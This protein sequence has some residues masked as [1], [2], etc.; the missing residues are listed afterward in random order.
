[1]TKPTKWHVRQAKTQISLAIHTIFRLKG[2]KVGL[3]LSCKSDQRLRCPHE[4]AWV[5]RYPFS[6]QRRLMRSAQADL[7]LFWAHVSFCWFCDEAAEMMNEVC[8]L[9]ML[10][11]YVGRQAYHLRR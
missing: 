4:K 3:L 11:I 5:L 1:M 6:A 7:S 8:L 9:V 10:I 2:R